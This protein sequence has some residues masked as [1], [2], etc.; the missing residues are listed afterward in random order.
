MTAV[1]KSAAVSAPPEKI[2]AVIRDVENYP[3][4]QK[5]VQK[6][7]LLESDDQGRPTLVKI[8]F[9]TMGMGGDY[10]LRYSY[11]DPHKLEYSLAEGEMMTKHEASYTLVPR[12]GGATDVQFS[13]EMAIKLPMPAFMINQMTQKG[14][15]DMLAGLRT[16]VEQG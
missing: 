1:T 3:S 5:E 9:S 6:V 13:L 15:R 7:E 16:R 11:P 12:E 8:F 14:V 10:T 4:W 2:L